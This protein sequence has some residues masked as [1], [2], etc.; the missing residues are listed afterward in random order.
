MIRH[1]GQSHEVHVI[2][3]A[4]SSEEAKAGERLSEYC[5]HSAVGIVS[6][7]I[8]TLRMIARLPTP[9]PS[10]LG[11]FHSPHVARLVKEKLNRIDF[12]LIV[13]HSSGMAQ[14][15][16][17]V[18]GI[19][20]L[21][22][23]CDMDSQKWLEYGVRKSLPLSLGY[24]LEGRKLELEE[25]RMARRFDLCTVATPAELATLDGYRTGA[26]TDWFPNG[27]DVEYFAPQRENYE[28]ETIT[29][30]GRMDYY[31]NEECMVRF[32]EQTLPLLRAQHPRL[33]LQIV[34]A[35][36]SRRVRRLGQA[37][38][39]IVTGSVPD[40]RPYL[41]RSALA[42]APLDIARG[43]QNKIL[44]AMASGVPVIASR[45]AAAGVDAVEGEHFLVAETPDEY[46]S[47]IGRV[48]SHPEERRLLSAAGRERVLHSHRWESSMR[49]MDRIIERCMAGR[50]RLDASPIALPRSQAIGVT[51]NQLVSGGSSH[52][53]S[54]P[55]H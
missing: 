27:V 53:G 20:K 54:M 49:R 22:D 37:S 36:P 32:C 9:I 15:V 23:F 48:L 50:A 6:D 19:R 47:A 1:L 38:G 12:D 44:E 33:R 4:R 43:T 52:V 25:K 14:Y 30:V 18:E 41:N 34:G 10:T 26:V 16:E 7:P 13:V 29:F 45:K 3:L 2:S 51:S 28:R 55:N 42:I 21:I 35:D 39:V 46:A 24:W 17:H 31:P 8:Q 11:Y 40:V 5:R